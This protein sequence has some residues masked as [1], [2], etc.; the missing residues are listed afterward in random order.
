MYRTHNNE[1]MIDDRINDSIYEKYH[2]ELMSNQSFHSLIR[3]DT[4]AYTH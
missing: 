4:S 2:I 1:V 3:D